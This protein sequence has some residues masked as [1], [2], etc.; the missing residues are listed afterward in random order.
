MGGAGGG[1]KEPSPTCN[2]EEFEMM[3]EVKIP[4]RYQAI[5][6]VFK[7][8]RMIMLTSL[9]VEESW[10]SYRELCAFWDATSNRD[11]MERIGEWRIAELLE[12]RRKLDRIGRRC[13]NG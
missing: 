11:G 1:C 4:A 5:A 10:R 7:K 9:T 12:R 6:H 13:A 2:E 8:E 3:A